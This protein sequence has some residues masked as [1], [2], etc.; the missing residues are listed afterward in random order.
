MESFITYVDKALGM[1]PIS[2]AEYIT[3]YKY[4]YDYCNS[5]PTRDFPSIFKLIR[6]RVLLQ[7]KEHLKILSYRRK[8][9]ISSFSDITILSAGPDLKVSHNDYHLS[10]SAYKHVE[11]R[12]KKILYRISKCGISEIDLDSKI[13]NILS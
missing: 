3:A 4:V 7:R 2:C 11:S 12:L 5:G 13:S 1:K 6:E 8:I 10:P 9:H